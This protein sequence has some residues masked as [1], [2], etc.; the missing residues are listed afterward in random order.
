MGKSLCGIVCLRWFNVKISINKNLLIIITLI[1]ILV[2]SNIFVTGYKIDPPATVHQHITKQAGDV[3]NS[4]PIEIS[5]HLLKNIS[6]PDI[7]SKYD[8]I[9]NDDIIA[10]LAVAWESPLI[11]T[12]MNNVNLLNSL[13]RIKENI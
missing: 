6:D 11:K 5:N 8:A 3:W 2:F 4:I 1:S 12:G 7:N 9:F 10:S 13:L